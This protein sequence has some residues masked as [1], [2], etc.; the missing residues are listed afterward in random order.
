MSNLGLGTKIINKLLDGVDVIIRFL[1]N[2]EN[3]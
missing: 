2:L 3:G 1:V